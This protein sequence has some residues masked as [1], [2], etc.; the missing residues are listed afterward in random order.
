MLSLFFFI[1]LIIFQSFSFSND[2]FDHWFNPFQKKIENKLLV[3]KF[4]INPILNRQLTRNMLEGEYHMMTNLP[5]SLLQLD[6]RFRSVL[7]SYRRYEL[8]DKRTEQVFI[9]DPNPVLNNLFFHIFNNKNKLF[10]KKNTDNHFIINMNDIEIKNIDVFMNSKSDLDSIKFVFNQN[11]YIISN[12]FIEEVHNNKIVSYLDLLE[13]ENIFD[14]RK[15]K[16]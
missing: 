14:L 11:S 8:Y 7:F 15:T 3:I 10:V 6:S 5:D 4:S 9:Q 1:S 2:L 16:K 13:P 12:I